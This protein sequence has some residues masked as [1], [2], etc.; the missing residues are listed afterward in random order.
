MNGLR[1]GQPAE[2]RRARL[3]SGVGWL[4]V[5]AGVALF[6]W[7]FWRQWHP[8]TAW[9]VAVSVAIG[10]GLGI[11]FDVGNRTVP[12]VLAVPDDAPDRWTRVREARWPGWRVQ[13]MGLVG[14]A[15]LFL[16]LTR[17]AVGEMYDPF[18]AIVSW[19]ALSGLGGGMVGVAATARRPWARAQ[20][21]R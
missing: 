7:F 20:G 9:K 5:H 12:A 4:A 8:I 18:G 15:L 11:A 17:R 13:A 21:R 14:A 16:G 19:I 6:F 2:V 10:F 1:V 3:G